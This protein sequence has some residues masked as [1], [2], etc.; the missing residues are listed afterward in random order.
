NTKNSTLQGFLEKSNV[1]PIREMTDLIETNRLV[2]RYQKAMT[3]FMDDL[4]KDAIEK[5][6]SVRA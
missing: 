1:N 4:Q 5:L 2:E 6:G 3:T